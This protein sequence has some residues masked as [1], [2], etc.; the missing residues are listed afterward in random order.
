MVQS[1][2]TCT[3][4]INRHTHHLEASA[5]QCSHLGHSHHR[6][7]VT[8]AIAITIAIN[9]IVSSSTDRATAATTAHRGRRAR[10][11]CSRREES[12]WE[13]ESPGIVVADR[14]RP[15]S[16]AQ[17]RAIVRCYITGY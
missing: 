13:L 16:V 6:R 5:D 3:V 10:E 12:W 7:I 17:Q 2:S 9:S 14:T 1:H 4:T 8:T 11:E 15:C